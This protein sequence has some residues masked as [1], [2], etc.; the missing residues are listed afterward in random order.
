MSLRNPSDRRSGR[1]RTR[2]P[3]SKLGVRIVD[4]SP[5]LTVTLVNDYLERQLAELN[6]QRVSDKNAVLLVQPSGVFPLVGPL[7]DPGET[8]CWTCMFDR[9][10]RNRE[11]KG[12]LERGPAQAVAVSP[13]S[14]NTFGQGAIQFAAVENRESDRERISH[15]FTQSRVSFDLM[16]STVNRHY[17]AKRPQCP[18][19]GNK[20]L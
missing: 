18:T 3:L 13:L 11:V 4:R 17:V 2:H 7:F 12:F 1:E 9:M 16:G 20:K 15:G 6:R 8:A 14:R 19:C 5:N 10:I